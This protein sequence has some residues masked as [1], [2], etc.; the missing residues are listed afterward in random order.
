M[1][2]V[3]G[4]KAWCSRTAVVGFSLAAW[5]CCFRG[6]VY[7]AGGLAWEAELRMN[8][9]ETR[10]LRVVT[11]E[12]KAKISERGGMEYVL[13]MDRDEMYWLDPKRRTYQ[14]VKLSEVERAAKGMEEQMRVALSK[15]KKELQSLPPEQRAMI[16]QMIANSRGEP[17]QRSPRAQVTKTGVQKTIAGLRCEEYV[18]EVEGKQRL[19]ACTTDQVPGFEAMRGEW[20]DVQRRMAEWMPMGFG[21][22]ADGFEKVPGFPLESEMGHLYAVVRKIESAAPPPSEFEVPAGYERR[23]GPLF[24]PVQ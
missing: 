5:T 7:G 6:A 13:R 12:R 15:M 24:P 23:P 14:V 17:A 10:H 3:R 21:R 16:E 8:A 20:L 2:G 1:S 11:A 4:V 22:G 18:V 9:G 19:R